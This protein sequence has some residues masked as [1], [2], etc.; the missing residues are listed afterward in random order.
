MVR[1]LVTYITRGR[2]AIVN[3]AH[4]LEVRTFSLYLAIFRRHDDSFL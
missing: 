3:F 4:T 2:H 1:V